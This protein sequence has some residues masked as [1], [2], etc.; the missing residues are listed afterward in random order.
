MSGAL[1]RPLMIHTIG[2]VAERPDSAPRA[3]EV[4]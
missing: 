1:Q 4:R 2:L 3:A